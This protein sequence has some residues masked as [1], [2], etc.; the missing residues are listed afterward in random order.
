M[1][2][3]SQR[4][5]IIDIARAAKTSVAT[6]SRVLTNANYP[7]SAKLRERILETATTL[8]YKP[9]IFSQMLKG[10]VN[11]LIGVIVPSIA[12]PFYSQ[13]VSN[14]ENFCI[15]AGYAPIICSSNNNPNLEYAHL[16]MLERQRV[17]GILLSTI[18]GS[19]M[20][21]KQ[22]ATLT[23]SCVFFDQPNAGFPGASVTFDFHQGGEMATNYLLNCG[24]RRI[25]FASPI[26]DRGSRKLIYDGYKEA[27]RKH[28]IRLNKD[29]V[30]LMQ[31]E[32][33]ETRD[34][35]FGMNLAARILDMN[36]LPDAIV[37]VNDITAIGIMNALA[38][39]GVQTPADI[40]IIGF[41]DI[42]F[43][44]MV[45]PALTTIRQSTLKTAELAVSAL[46]AH[47][48]N[49]DLEPIHAI[50]E[51]ELVERASVRSIHPR[52][53]KQT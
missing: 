40:S 48:A 12:N 44:S 37:A 24:H 45:T 17:S 1:R 39:G 26:I 14:V 49:P 42:A 51:P 35:E 25:A 22:I 34:Y 4:V 6:V 2:I 16:E 5:T 21:V 8:D 19:K 47:I 38:E 9:N 33:G 18:T 11:K 28:N 32:S 50:V 15:A 30:A 46:F 7:V 23:T 53:R 31:T 3:P 29:R 13:L 10:G 52:I 36:Y 41:D 43:S 27:L 20:L